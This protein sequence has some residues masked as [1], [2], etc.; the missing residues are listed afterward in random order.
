MKKSLLFSL[1]LSGVILLS[2]C[3]EV[4]NYDD[5]DEIKTV[6]KTTTQETSPDS[7]KDLPV[8]SPSDK[9]ATVTI[10]SNTTTTPEET[11]TTTTTTTKKVTTTT[12]T[13]KKTT[14]TTTTAKQVEWKGSKAISNVVVSV[15]VTED[16]GI[17]HFEFTLE[18]NSKNPVQFFGYQIAVI[19]GKS[20]T[21][22]LSNTQ[23]G[24]GAT[25]TYDYYIEIPSSIDNITIDVNLWGMGLFDSSG[26]ITLD[27]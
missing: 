24:S 15:T 16:N 10:E 18:N 22:K 23:C 12:T 3:G 21:M 6:V 20:Y 5:Y 27:K 14:T 25:D 13:P 1:A 19:N 26:E 7:E 4:A 2:A 9:E 8:T 11:T 17:A